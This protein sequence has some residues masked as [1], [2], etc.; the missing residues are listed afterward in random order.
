MDAELDMI[1]LWT[2]RSKSVVGHRDD[3]GASRAY[4]KIQVPARQEILIVSRDGEE[5]SRVTFTT[6]GHQDGT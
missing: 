4:H 1:D 3:L 6:V 2:N 5:V